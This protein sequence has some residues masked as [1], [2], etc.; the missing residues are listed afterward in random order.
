MIVKKGE[1]I[2]GKEDENFIKMFGLMKAAEI[3][4]EHKKEYKTPFIHDLFQLAAYLGL[5]KKDF[6]RLLKNVNNE[7]EFFKVKK[8]NGG[9]RE[10]H[11][12]SSE[13]RR[14]QTTILRR[15]LSCYD[16]SPYACAYVKGK[17]LPA[18]AAP[19]TG[20]KFILKMDITDF[21]GSIS[22]EQVISTVFNKKLFPA[23]VGYVLTTL[24]CYKGYLVQGAPT[25]PALS[26]LVLKRFDDVMGAWCEKRNISYTRYCDDITF[27]A[28][29]PP[30][31]AYSKAKSFLNDMGFEINK[32]KTRFVANTSSQKVT[33][34]VVNEK[35]S[36]PKKYKRDLRQKIYYFLKFDKDDIAFKQSG[37]EYCSYVNY[38]LGRANY[39][40][41]IEPDDK[42]LIESLPK[43]YDKLDFPR[44]SGF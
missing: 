17:S 23:C 44:F 10:I 6:F 22:F 35:V 38:L 15:I 34:L 36:V 3:A 26:N 42:F 8:K 2:F 41:S 43:L 13:L 39:V 5:G 11:A 9:F 31:A 40:L 20:K 16:V 28:N 33:G 32:K 25:S 14:V 7:Y 37:R 29:E 30:F 21:F 19:H 4:L 1:V 27:S 24:C 18:N 12:P